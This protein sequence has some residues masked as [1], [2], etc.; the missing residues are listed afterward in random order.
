[1]P[2]TKVAGVG[3][4]YEVLGVEGA[5]AVLCMGGW[6]TFCHGRTRDLPRSLVEDYR[7]VVFDYPGVGAS[8]DDLSRDAST[9]WYSEIAAEL[10][11]VIGVTRVAI[12]GM[13]GLGGCVAQELAIA[14]P[15]LVSRLFLMGT[16]C[17]ADAALRDQLELFRD[18]HLRMGFSEFQRLCAVYSFEPDFYGRNRGRLLGPD[19]A[20]AD[21][22]NRELTHARL[23]QACLTHDTRERLARIGVPSVVVHAGADVI[24]GPR[25]TR[26]VEKRL[27]RAS[28]YEW[29]ECAHIVAGRDGKVRLSELLREFLRDAGGGASGM[30][31]D[32]LRAVADSREA[33]G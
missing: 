28:G 26:E 1:M 25:Y 7:V 12:V 32:A 9:S 33:G 11:D 3:L 14:R 5:P 30:G 6:G 21:L 29:R 10:L 16:W 19:G 31:A 22:R 8:E 24:T 4:Y 20:W 15:D 18:V 2:R 27:P 23:V 13:V 17:A